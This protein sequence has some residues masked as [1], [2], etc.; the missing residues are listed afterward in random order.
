MN[1]KQKLQL[2]ILICAAIF[3]ALVVFAGWPLFKSIKSASE[4]MALE[5]AIFSALKT[6]TDSLDNFQKNYLANEPILSQIKN[7]FV[8]F[9][10][11]VD[12]IEFLEEQAFQSNVY[13]EIL[14]LVSFS[15]QQDPWQTLNFQII[16]AG[17]FIDCRAFLETLE[18]S[19]AYLFSLFIF[20]L[21][22]Q[23]ISIY[24]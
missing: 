22:Q 23:N 6:Q 24:F 8:D 19:I 18:N 10:A 17:S 13:L 3:I 21:H 16:I 1:V 4:R 15:A 12:F 9:K 5:K 7:S 14:P 20:I 2:N 11:P